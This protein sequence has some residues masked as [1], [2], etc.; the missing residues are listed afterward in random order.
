[1]GHLFL[2][3]P[4]SERKKRPISKDPRLASWVSKLGGLLKHA[5]G[6]WR[7]V[8]SQKIT[9]TVFDSRG[10]LIIA[11]CATPEDARL[12]ATSPQL[13]DSLV[14]LISLLETMKPG[15][16]PIADQDKIARA[17]HMI[18]FATNGDLGYGTLSQHPDYP[19]IHEALKKGG[20]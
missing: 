15:S 10:E 4:S 6:P 13:L 9:C 5:P 18:S 1:M 3:I 14:A 11:R 19:E 12:I 2:T 17:K 20:S 8:D 16:L 7:F